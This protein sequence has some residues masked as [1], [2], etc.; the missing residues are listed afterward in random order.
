MKLAA[1]S[2]LALLVTLP[3]ACEQPEEDA[4][5][6]PIGQGAEDDD[7]DGEDDDEEPIDEEPGDSQFRDCVDAT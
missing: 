5:A 3:L 7:D 6:D 1:A 2:V 4:S